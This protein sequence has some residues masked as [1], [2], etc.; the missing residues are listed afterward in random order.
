AWRPH[1]NAPDPD[2]RLRLGFLSPDLGCHPVGYFLIRPLEHLDP[3]QAEVVCYSDRRT[4]DEL[5]ARFRAAAA[6]WR[7]VAGWD[8]DRLAQQ[9][10][11]DG[12]DILFDLAGHPAHNRLLVF[13][14]KPAPLQVTWLGYEGT[15]GLG[16]MDYLLADRH[17]VPPGA[18][19]HYRERLLRLP[20]GYV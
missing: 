16:A 2:R 13:A 6:L 20:D 4:P 15:T 11:A 17:A 1:A 18:E 14:R 3:Q 5:T 19:A 8:D 7:D 12:I 10:R 9:I